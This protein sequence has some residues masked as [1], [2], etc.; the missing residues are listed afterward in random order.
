MKISFNLLIY[1]EDMNIIRR[2]LD[3]VVDLVDE[4]VVYVDHKWST[5]ELVE[6]YDITYIKSLDLDSSIVEE[7]RNDMIENSRYDWI[8]ILDPDE[9][10]GVSAI[11]RIKSYR[12][13]PNRIDS[14]VCAFV[15]SRTNI[16]YDQWRKV[17]YANNYPDYQ[18]RLLSRDLRY[19]GKIHMPPTIPKGSRI[20]M[21]GGNIFHDKR[22]ETYEE[23]HRK[24]LL[25][26]SKGGHDDVEL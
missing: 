22:H 3:S 4:I 17:I 5:K 14:R 26:R 8:L 9:Y 2:C 6:E 18:I 25:Y 24:L 16:E 23:W 10:L 13:N 20:M 11:R 19:P 7:H 12:D 15:F 1:N 21:L